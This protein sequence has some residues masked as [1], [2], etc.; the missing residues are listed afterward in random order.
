MRRCLARLSYLL[1]PVLFVTACVPATGTS[2]AGPTATQ[3]PRPKSTVAAAST[4]E[5]DERALRGL[6]IDVWHPW[7]AG[8]EAS[9]LESLTAQFNQENEWGIEVVLTGQVN[10]SYLYENVTTSLPT[11]R[12]PD[13]V[14]ALPEHARDWDVDGYVVDLAAYVNDAVYGWDADQRRDFPAVFWSQDEAGTG[15][16]ALPAQRGARYLLWNQGWA[17][18]LGFG[19]PPDDPQDLQQQA[20][21]AHRTML[22]DAGPGNDGLGG[23]IID[24]DAMTAMSWLLAFEGGVLEGDGYRFLTPNNI[25]AFRFV[26]TLQQEGCAW[27]IQPGG[28]PLAAFA[29]REALFAT[30]GLEDFADQARAFAAANN[31]DEWIALA[32]PGVDQDALLLYGSSYILLESSPEEQLA[33]WL[34]IRWMLEP[35]NDARWVQ[36]TGL[37]PLRTSTVDLLTDYAAG[38]P[39]WAQAVDLISEAQIQPQLAS[40]RTVKVMVGDGFDCLFR[41]NPQCEQAPVVLRQMET[42]A[43]ELSD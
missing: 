6:S 17:D 22:A 25:D 18:E 38:H 33:G 13:L 3:T 1:V 4:L 32:Y 27:Q 28:D 21:R 23:W 29:A 11:P 36:A 37:L 14:I 42:I 16:L 19:S 30:A 39:Q 24:T 35:E 7:F 9:L 40:W 20:C 26:K 34:F 31:T 10:Y 12:R 43:Q 15:R 2:V 5:V 8:V 41:G